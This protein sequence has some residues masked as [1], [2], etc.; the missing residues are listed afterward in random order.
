MDGPKY[1]QEHIHVAIEEKF[2][3]TNSDEKSLGYEAETFNWDEDEVQ[4]SSE[5]INVGQ[6]DENY[7]DDFEVIK[8]IESTQKRKPLKSGSKKAKRIIKQP[9]P[10][11][12]GFTAEEE[13]IIDN[14][15]FPDEEQRTTT[16]EEQVKEIND[17]IEIATNLFLN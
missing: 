2:M 4:K 1:G 12:T 15:D 9:E 14:Y 16:K 13:D 17:L 8:S 10:K 6:Y 11:P 3:K 5:K 7:E